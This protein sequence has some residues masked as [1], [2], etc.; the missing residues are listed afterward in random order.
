MLSSIS[1]LRETKVK[2]FEIGCGSDY[3]SFNMW[4]EYFH[5]GQIFSMDINEEKVTD[6]GIVFKGDQN[7]EDDYKRDHPLLLHLEVTGSLRVGT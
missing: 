5:N 4:K 1:G 6:N 7:N 2:L 3:A